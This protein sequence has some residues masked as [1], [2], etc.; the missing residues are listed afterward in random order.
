M[1]NVAT[2]SKSSS[3]LFTRLFRNILIDWGRTQLLVCS[4]FIVLLALAPLVIHS[5]YYLGILILTVLYAIIGISW[6]I[7]AGF[8]G[9]LL[10]ANIIFVAFGAY[11]TI[12]LANT[13]NISPWIGLPISGFVA[14][15]GGL[16]VAF[17]SLRYGLKADYFALFTVGLMTALRAIFLKWDFVGGS[18]GMWVRLENPS[19]S[20]MVFANKGPYLYIALGLLIIYLLIQYLLYSSKTGK[21]FIAIREDEAAAAALG[22]NTTLY[23]TLALVIGSALAGVGGG[24]Y[25]MYVT[26]IDPTQIFNLGLNVEIA[27]AAPVIGGLGSIAGP[28]LGALLNKPLAELIRGLLTTGSNGMTLIIY[29][30][31]VIIAVLFM[32]RGITGLLHKAYLKLQARL[33]NENKDLEG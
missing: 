17:I 7:V 30:S 18:V 31:F 15:I 28:F 27:I 5:P 3:N 16:I 2:K 9:Q 13:Y 24:F 19:F 8:T 23:K 32:P 20:R 33:L 6:N 14:A 10:I 21:Y 4:V 1:I 22:I 25:I 26:F 12:V 29:G 11:T